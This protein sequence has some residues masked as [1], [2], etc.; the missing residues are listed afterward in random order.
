MQPAG[1]ILVGRIGKVHGIKGWMRLHSF[2]QP[3]EEILAY[4]PWLIKQKNSWQELEVEASKAHHGSLLIKLVGI[5]TP[6][7]AQAYVNAELIVKREQLP[8]LADDEFYWN[9]LLGFTVVTQAGIELGKLDHWLATGANDVIVVKGEKE[10][11]IPFV[12]QRFIVE[13]DT[14]AKRIT[15]DWDPEF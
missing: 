6:E 11:L 8:A 4:Q 2:T 12:M 10:H 3:I 14:A 7:S 5:E 15:V 13:V 9:D 1:T